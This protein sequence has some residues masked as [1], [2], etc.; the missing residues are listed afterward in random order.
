[1]LS[2]A[3]SAA[4]LRGAP[5]CSASSSALSVDYTVDHPAEYDLHYV[6]VSLSSRPTKAVAVVTT[7]KFPV[8]V[9][10]LHAGQEYLI[11]VR[12]HPK[13]QP[14]IAW[15]PGWSAPSR[16]QRCNTSSAAPQP[17]AFAPT[18]SSSRLLRVYRISEYAF[19]VDFLENHDAASADAMPLYLM[20]CDPMGNC[21]PWALTDLTS[22]W[23]GC[24][25]ALNTL[26]PTERGGAF[27]CMACADKHR[28][29]LEVACGPWSDDD[30]LKGEGS[31]GVHWFCGVGWPESVAQEGPISEYCIEYLPVEAP[32]VEA[33]P[34]E[35]PPV[36]APPAAATELVG[37]GSD[38]SDGFAG[39]LSCNSDEVDALGNDP[40][41][42]SCICIC[43][44]DRLLAHQTID[45]LK[46]DCFVGTL[47]WVN[48]TVC[49]CSGTQS[50]EPAVSNP[51]L[52]HV[53]RA[54][55]FMP[56]VGVKMKPERSYTNIASGFNFHFP[57]GGA[58]AEDAPLG[59]E[60]CTWRRAPTV[61]MLYGDDLIAA[62]W[63]RAFVPDTAT[64]VSHS[65]ANIAAFARAVRALDAAAMPVSCGDK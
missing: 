19:D 35:A 22:R 58:C 16:S 45:Q 12:S 33:P 27:G 21:A 11:A 30:T 34:V 57:K 37:S 25:K 49:N 1:M 59:T 26:C 4:A 38:P 6:T 24:Q 9:E 62:G 51:S 56:Y 44:D 7:R 55:V 17:P 42:P 10:G 36:E 39:Y 43:Y 53:G 3:T 31:F 8:S 60:G 50:P 28:A 47:P 29:A 40:R 41:D 13:S 54:P 64:N 14:T 61:R 20:T 48:E 2:L 23:D 46:Q 65:R 5:T 18:A 63:D 52:K 15:G 32:P